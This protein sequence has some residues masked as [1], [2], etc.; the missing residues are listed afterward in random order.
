MFGSLY[1]LFLP[2]T[3]WQCHHHCC[4]RRPYVWNISVVL[5]NSLMQYNVT[6]VCA[7]DASNMNQMLILPELGS[8]LSKIKWCYNYVM[9]LTSHH[10]LFYSLLKLQNTSVKILYVD[11]LLWAFGQPL[12]YI[13]CFS[14]RGNRLLFL[15]VSKAN[16]ADV[17]S[18]KTSLRWS[19]KTPF[20]FVI[21]EIR[22]FTKVVL[23]VGRILYRKSWR[24]L[25]SHGHFECRIWKGLSSRRRRPWLHLPTARLWIRAWEFTGGRQNK[26]SNICE[27]TWPD[28]LWLAERA[29]AGSPPAW[30]QLW[31]MQF[32]LPFPLSVG[33]LEPTR[34]TPLSRWSRASLG[35]PLIYWT[36]SHR[37]LF[38]QCLTYA[39]AAI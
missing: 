35:G 38:S 2:A 15:K 6:I 29:A 21:Q 20:K 17:R 33:G 39:H 34:G 10:I 14:L 22:I 1:R 13:S 19:L 16:I 9:I 12:F 25:F 23:S 5:I 31:K 37:G 4:N 36:Y 3:G 18:E 8:F 28:T 11:F 30:K 32:L 27:E 26:A 24:S 7:S